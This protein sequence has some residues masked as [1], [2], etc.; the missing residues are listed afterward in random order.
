MNMTD[1]VRQQARLLDESAP[2][3]DGSLGAQLMLITRAYDSLSVADELASVPQ[4]LAEAIAR[5]DAALVEAIG[6]FLAEVAGHAG[7]VNH[8]LAN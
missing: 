4:V 3:Q 2:G 8:A 6:H 5:N 7:T 1:Y